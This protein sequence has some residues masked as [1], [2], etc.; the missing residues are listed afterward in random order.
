MVPTYV[1]E[2][3]ETTYSKYCIEKAKLYILDKNIYLVNMVPFPHY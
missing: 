3:K 2:N 1:K